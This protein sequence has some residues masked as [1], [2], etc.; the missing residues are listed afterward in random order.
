MTTFVLP[1]LALMTTCFLTSP[2]GN[3]TGLVPTVPEPALNEA[4]ASFAM[5]ICMGFPLRAGSPSRLAISQ[6]P[7][8]ALIGERTARAGNQQSPDFGVR[9]RQNGSGVI[10]TPKRTQQ[11]QNASRIGRAVAQL[12]IRQHC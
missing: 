10:V 6:K 4:I 9:I 3:C 2:P 1:A 12:Q 11:M 7:F 5:S 8:N